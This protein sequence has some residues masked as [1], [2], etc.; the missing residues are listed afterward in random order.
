MPTENRVMD[1]EERSGGNCSIVSD[2]ENCDTYDFARFFASATYKSYGDEE[3]RA[4]KIEP[5]AEYHVE[6]DW[7]NPGCQYSSN[8]SGPKK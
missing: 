8:P 1:S 3:I 4:R 7:S 2:I 6:L 5:A